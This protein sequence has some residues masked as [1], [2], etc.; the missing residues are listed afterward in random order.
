MGTNSQEL[1]FGVHRKLDEF[2]AVQEENKILRS[3]LAVF[4]AAT[5]AQGATDGIVVARVDELSPGDLRELA[6]AVRQQ[7]GIRAVV[8]GG[9][10]P[11]GGVSLVAA[12]TPTSGL[13]ATALIK[14]AA[15]AVGG[16]SGGKGD[17]ATAGGKLPEHLPE[18]LRLAEVAARS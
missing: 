6:L 1:L 2:K 9:L 12:V 13:S 3:R 4:G 14:D 15:K 16:G 8:L 5:L 10:T 7:V 18:A 11:E 17:I